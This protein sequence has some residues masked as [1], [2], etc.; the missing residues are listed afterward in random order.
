M[1]TAVPMLLHSAIRIF[2][3][4]QT[5]DRLNVTA[6]AKEMKQHTLLGAT[7]LIH[8]CLRKSSMS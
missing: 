1:P 2:P 5:K 7:G 3:N 4:F 6:Y 8:S